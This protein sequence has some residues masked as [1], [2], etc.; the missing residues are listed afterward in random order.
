[1]FNGVKKF[2]IEQGSV[3]FDSDEILEA[4]ASQT[5]DDS[6]TEMIKMVLCGSDDIKVIN[7]HASDVEWII[8][9]YT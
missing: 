5:S 9:D 4:E 3:P 2:E 7:I 6:D 8:T 1:M